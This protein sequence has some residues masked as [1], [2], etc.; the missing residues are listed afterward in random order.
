MT[1]LSLL[2]NDETS[3]RLELLLQNLESSTPSIDAEPVSL[4]QLANWCNTSEAD[5]AKHSFTHM[6][7]LLTFTLHLEQ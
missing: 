4:A 1:K 7:A 3:S 5:I 2:D 6:R